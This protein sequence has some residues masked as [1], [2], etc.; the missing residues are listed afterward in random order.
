MP[1]SHSKP[2]RV[3]LNLGHPLAGGLIFAY[4]FNEP[5]GTI[6][7]TVRDLVRPH[8]T[9][10]N[11]LGTITTTDRSKCA[12]GGQTTGLEIGW[13]NPSRWWRTS[14]TKYGA[15]EVI[16]KRYAP[17]GNTD[18]FHCCM[19]EGTV[20]GT[21]DCIQISFRP[22]ILQW[23]GDPFHQLSYDTGGS[24]IGVWASWVLTRN[25]TSLK[26]YRD[27]VLVASR[28]DLNAAFTP[29]TIN[30]RAIRLGAPV[31]SGS[32]PSGI[33]ASFR[34][35]DRPLAPDEVAELYVDPWAMYRMRLP[36]LV[37][38]GLPSLPIDITLSPFTD[39]DSFP[40]VTVEQEAAITLTPFTDPDSFPEVF[41]RMPIDITLAP[42][43][44][45]DSFPEVL[46]Q[47]EVA[48]EQPTP[49]VD[50][51]GSRDDVFVQVV[52]D[53]A[54]SYVIEGSEDDTEFVAISPVLNRSTLWRLDPALPYVRVRRTTGGS[55]SFVV[56]YGP[57]EGRI[58][59]REEG[60]VS[61]RIRYSDK[62]TRR[63]H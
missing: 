36:G 35:W 44:D 11:G 54:P 49:S 9:G 51:G 2:S 41:V 29:G 52:V 5:V 57:Q 26:L 14:S 34:I 27:G 16:V 43:V 42:F 8:L 17:G 61:P 38:Y 19:I 55:G 4:P 58:E 20:G 3:R 24:D 39:A 46:V 15:V 47:S 31:G 59:G 62:D 18:S 37:P 23:F 22:F 10:I 32:Q 53:G 33:Y 50:I 7:T 1:A 63:V 28:N 60:V 12:F 56:Y 25:D 6:N 21:N 30:T 45:G 40:D 48:E 13:P